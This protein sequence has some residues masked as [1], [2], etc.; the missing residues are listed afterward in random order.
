MAQFIARI[1]LR[2]RIPIL[3]LLGI[4]TVFMAYKARKVEM[5][6]NF[7]QLLPEYD[8]TYVDYQ[9]FKGFFKEDGNQLILGIDFDQ[10]KTLENFNAWYEMGNT[11]KTMQAPRVIWENNRWDTV[12]LPAVD[13][14][15]SVAHLYTLRKNTAEKQFDFVNLI[16]KKP[17]TQEELDS[18]LQK[19][20]NLPFY[21]GLVYNESSNSTLMVIFVNRMTLN[22]NAREVFVDNLDELLAQQEGRFGR[23]HRT[24]VPYIRTII[25]LKT[26]EELRF[27]I[28]ISAAITALL[29]YLFFR[30]FKVVMYSMLAVAIGVTWSLGVISLLGFK[31]SGLMGLIPSLIIVIGVPNSVY[32]INKYHQEFRAH[33][34][35]IK[36]LNRVIRKIG[37]A[38]LL[39]NATTALGFATFIFTKSRILIEFGIAAS[40]NIMLVFVLTIFI[41][42]IVFS[43]LGDPKPRHVKHLDRMWVVR[44]INLLV[45]FVSGNRRT[46]YYISVG[47]F[48]L[49]IIGIARIHTTGNMVDDLPKGDQVKEDLVYFQDS[50]KG[51]LPL[52]VLIDTK[53]PGKAISTGTLRRIERLQAYFDSIPE[54]SR[55]LSITDALKFAKQ[56]YYNGRPSKYS[57]I[58]SREKSFIAPYLKGKKDSTQQGSG[59]MAA[60]FLDPERRFVRITLQIADVGTV[61]LE[62][63]LERI[64]PRVN[65]IFDPEDFQ[66][67]F[68]GNSVAYLKGTSYLVNNLFISLTIAIAIIAVLMAILFR[69]VRMTLISML[70]NLLPLLFT[71]GVMGW[72]GIPLKVS[73]I[74][75]FSIAF[76]ISI[77]DTIHYLAKFRQELSTQ[78]NK[79]KPAVLGA[80]RE[81]G[82]SMFYTSIILFFGFGV[83]TFSDFGSTI[84]LGTLVSLTLLVAMFANL[85]LLPALLLSLDQR[86]AIK[87]MEEPSF[88]M[89]DRELDP[90]DSD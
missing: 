79:I 15:F 37:S 36:A 57:L 58:G 26:K 25:T 40:I 76:G 6:Y 3:I 23:I 56:A 1:I 83:F 19:I 45:L 41:I 63:L 47:V 16:D 78:K 21:R 34:N 17:E 74:L 87:A 46:I 88:E 59:N 29:L 22:T 10:L 69:S 75:V 64:Q 60:G 32:L 8:S 13:S 53:K 89:I 33:G 84:A 86:I 20:D 5:D 27:F 9:R 39:T 30:S 66:V 18:L 85:V 55:S 11:I 67:V 73:T 71:G 12:I 49:S 2:N 31:L 72:F 68:T 82:L 4:V 24:G 80:L 35:K 81:T 43:L 70:P 65:Q 44:F 54:F 62:E 90:N 52:E 14:V 77:D 61:E 38:T 7:A 51:V 48:V 42:P 50:Y 28:A